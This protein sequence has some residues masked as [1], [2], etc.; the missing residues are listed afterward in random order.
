MGRAEERGLGTWRLCLG[1]WEHVFCDEEIHKA[2]AGV[3]VKEKGSKQVLTALVCDIQ[4]DN[5]QKFLLRA[6]S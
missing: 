1:P 4:S 3:Q 6:S 5:G 2:R